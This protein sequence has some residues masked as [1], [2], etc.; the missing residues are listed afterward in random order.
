MCLCL[1]PTAV[2]GLTDT[3]NAV[4]RAQGLGPQVSCMMSCIGTEQRRLRGLDH[5][6]SG[7]LN[8][9]SIS[10]TSAQASSWPP[11]LSRH[12]HK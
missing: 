10:F 1:C 2:V 9:P 12:G 4:L 8:G 6:L 3:C 5:G 7:R 11:A